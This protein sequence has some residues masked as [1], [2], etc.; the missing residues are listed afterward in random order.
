MDPSLCI[1]FHEDD[2]INVSQIKT[3]KSYSSLVAMN[4]SAFRQW[5]S[6]LFMARENFLNRA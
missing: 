2:E 4:S 3:A 6:D 5:S 1:P